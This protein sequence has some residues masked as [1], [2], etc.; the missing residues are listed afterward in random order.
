MVPRSSFARRLRL[1]CNSTEFL[2][3]SRRSFPRYFN[4]MVHYMQAAIDNV[5]WITG[6]DCTASGIIGSVEDVQGIKEFPLGY[7]TSTSFT[8]QSIAFPESE[9]G[10]PYSLCC[11]LNR[12]SCAAKPPTSI[13]DKCIG[14]SVWFGFRYGR[15]VNVYGVSRTLFIS[16][17][18]RVC[19]PCGRGAF[20]E[21]CV[22]YAM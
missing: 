2:S 17:T 8:G 6:S 22:S 10:G 1:Q 11:E 12:V 3:S 18:K 19:R 4:L 15:Q 9:I 5:K 16:N 14:S 13:R 20:R 7:Y 21:F